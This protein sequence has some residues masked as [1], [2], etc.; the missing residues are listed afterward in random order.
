MNERRTIPVMSIIGCSMA[1]LSLAW[2]VS[3]TLALLLYPLFHGYL[4]H[5]V[6]GNASWVVYFSTG[7][8]RVDY[9]T[10]ASAFFV[11]FVLFPIVLGVW[12]AWRS[13][14]PRCES[15]GA[16][17]GFGFLMAVGLVFNLWVAAIYH[18]SHWNSSEPF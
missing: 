16:W 13:T 17:L 2:F 12:I 3:G 11:A 8:V 15:V 18:L 14:Q 7:G 10:M 4:D 5:T 6:S 1:A 9:R